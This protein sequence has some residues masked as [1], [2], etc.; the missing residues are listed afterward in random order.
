MP[1]RG[2][3]LVGGVVAAALAACAIAAASC[4]ASSDVSREL[5][6]ICE[7]SDDCEDRCLTGARYPDGFCSTTCDS[8]A[9]CPSGAACAE[10][11][12]GVCLFECDRSSDCA[13][14]GPEW[15]C[16]AQPRPDGGVGDEVL[17]CIGSL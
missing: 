17:V 2:S 1:V 9:D 13:F 10:R 16:R 4:S 3:S 15:A 7:E 5:G 14:L 12:G 11:D 6:A 8:D